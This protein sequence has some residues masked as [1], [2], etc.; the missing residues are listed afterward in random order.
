LP[1]TTLAHSTFA[2]NTVNHLFGSR[3]FDTRDESH[4]NALTAVFAAGEG[5]HN[6]HRYQR[7]A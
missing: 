4:N 2:I 1:T 3:R 7:G 6:H 5:W